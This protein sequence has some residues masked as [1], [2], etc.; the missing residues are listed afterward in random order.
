MSNPLPIASTLTI[1]MFS[2]ATS[3]CFDTPTAS[4]ETDG[5]PTATDAVDE[6]TQGD[7]TDDDPGDPVVVDDEL[8]PRIRAAVAAWCNAGDVC[9][10][11]VDYEICERATTAA[12]FSEQVRAQARGLTLDVAC[13][14]QLVARY[15]ADDCAEASDSWM[16][17][18]CTLWVGSAGAF[19]PCSIWPNAEGG[20]VCGPSL[21]CGPRDASDAYATVCQ[22]TNQG[23]GE[24]CV[25]GALTCEEGLMCAPDFTGGSAI[26]TCTDG[27][28]GGLG[29]PCRTADD[30]TLGLICPDEVCAEPPAIGE[31]CEGYLS[32]GL[33][34]YCVDGTCAAPRCLWD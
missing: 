3:A 2:L 10:C 28:P 30:C 7:P 9:D 14:D 16:G 20:R 13:L 19:E 22:P 33:Y 4:G 34:G 21:A 27:G 32:C 12:W 25:F 6:P 23:L 31:S 1:L 29:E 24:P 18:P 5:E 17:Q 8:D 15:S 11:G 26:A